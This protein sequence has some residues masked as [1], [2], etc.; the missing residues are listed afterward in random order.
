MRIVMS[1]LEPILKQIAALGRLD[2]QE[3]KAIS[4]IISSESTPLGSRAT[5]REWLILK[6]L[7]QS[8]ISATR[9]QTGGY[10]DVVALADLIKIEFVEQPHDK[11]D[12]YTITDK[13]KKFVK[14]TLG[15]MLSEAM[16]SLRADK[17]PVLANTNSVKCQFTISRYAEPFAGVNNDNE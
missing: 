7:L 17:V 13:G 10:A 11:V 16:T 9:F 3:R 8:D 12:V 4:D 5:E 2:M 6:E 15:E 1:K 14:D